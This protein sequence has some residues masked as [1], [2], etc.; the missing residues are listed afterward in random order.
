[1]FGPEVIE[2]KGRNQV[3]QTMFRG[4]GGSQ[5][6]RLQRMPPE[7][8]EERVPRWNKS[9]EG[10]H[11]KGWRG[12]CAGTIITASPQRPT[13]WVEGTPESQDRHV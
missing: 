2:K 3:N 6:T 10:P 13:R 11:E 8:K 1:M 9:G 7:C 4:S 12:K 5:T